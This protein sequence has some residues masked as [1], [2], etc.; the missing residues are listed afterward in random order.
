MMMT[1]MS[2]MI[3]DSIQYTINDTK[4]FRRANRIFLNKVYSVSGES[5]T[6]QIVRQCIPDTMPGHLEVGASSVGWALHHRNSQLIVSVPLVMCYRFLGVCRSPLPRFHTPSNVTDSTL[7]QSP[8]RRSSFAAIVNNSWP[9]GR[10][11]GFALR[12]RRRTTTNKT[13]RILRRT[14]D[15]TRSFLSSPK[16]GCVVRRSVGV[17]RRSHTS[18]KC[19]ATSW[20]KLPLTSGV[21][22]P[23][24]AQGGGRI[25]RPFVLG[26]WNWRACLKHKSHVMST[27]T[28]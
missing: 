19:T 27:V 2:L 18:T 15:E 11:L 4:K 5:L 13:R 17:K 8:R 1:M 9:V 28:T 23:M 24:A 25:C 10:C 22:G 6:S 7:K 14:D 21:A 3:Q 16:D 26:F 12:R 20:W